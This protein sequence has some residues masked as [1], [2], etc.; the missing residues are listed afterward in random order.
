MVRRA[1]FNNDNRSVGVK[2]LE[3]FKVWE[4]ALIQDIFP[5]QKP[6]DSSRYFPPNKLLRFEYLLWVAL[7]F[8]TSFVTICALLLVV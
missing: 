8:R 1:V 2:L 7:P 4:K 6:V 3:C 5:V